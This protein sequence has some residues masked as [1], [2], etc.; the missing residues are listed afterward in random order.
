MLA[1]KGSAD[2]YFS[3]SFSTIQAV[4]MEKILVLIYLPLFG[5][6]WAHLD[7]SNY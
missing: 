1:A 3:F 5:K 7:R 2:D 4:K 6:S